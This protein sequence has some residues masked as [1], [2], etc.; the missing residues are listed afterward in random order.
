MSRPRVDP[1]ARV[2]C[3]LPGCE[4]AVPRRLAV[5]VSVVFDGT[6]LRGLACSH[7][8]ALELQRGWSTRDAYGVQYLPPTRQ[9]ALT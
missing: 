6:R 7:S 3:E 9:G 8:C 4:V 2:V 1:Y 5:P